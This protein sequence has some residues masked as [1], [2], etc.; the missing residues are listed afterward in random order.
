LVTYFSTVY[1]TI[2]NDN[3]EEF[4]IIR[5]IPTVAGRLAMFGFIYLCLQNLQFFFIL[6]MVTIILLLALFIWKGKRLSS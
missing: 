2:K 4:M 1:K 5:E 6:P 3:E